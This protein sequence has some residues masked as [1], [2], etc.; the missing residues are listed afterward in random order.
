MIL[1]ALRGAHQPVREGV[2][3]ERVRERGAAVSPEEFLVLAQ[4]LVT[5]GLV[6]AAVEHDLPANDPSPFQPRF[7]RP[8]T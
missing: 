5:L 4:D 7:Y 6:R 1:D 2:L 3:Y 8:V